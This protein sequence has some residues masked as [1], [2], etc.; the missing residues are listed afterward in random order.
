[1]SMA[2]TSP[3]I[4][5]DALE[6]KDRTGWFVRIR[7]PHGARSYI[8]GFTSQLE[9]NEWIQYEA[10]RWLKR[11]QRGLDFVEPSLRNAAKPY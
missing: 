3:E 7:L 5:F 4:A 11:V 6:M 9:A 10:D 2:E 8:N 1:M